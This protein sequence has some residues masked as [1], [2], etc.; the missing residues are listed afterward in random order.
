MGSFYQ[1]KSYMK[2]AGSFYQPTTYMKGGKS[3]R[4][5]YKRK[6]TKGGFYPS[7]MSNLVKSGG[8]L[9]PL[10]MRAGYSLYNSFSK[11]RKNKK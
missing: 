1:P 5:G 7:V 9:M 11:T 8:I 6:T 2:G 3:K 10:A 4:R